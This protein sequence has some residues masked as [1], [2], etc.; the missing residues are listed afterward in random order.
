MLQ[1]YYL[2]F[3]L[4]G[5][6]QDLIHEVSKDRW[7][8]LRMQLSE[9]RADTSPAAFICFDT[10]NGRSIAIN[11]D[12]LQAVCYLW[13]LAAPRRDAAT[14]DVWS[15]LKLV[16]K[17]PWALGFVDDAVSVFDFFCALELG[18][19]MEPFPSFKDEDGEL[20]QV[21]AEE[22]VWFDVPTQL[23]AR[24]QDALD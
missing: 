13:N 12:Q 10:E 22:V 24:G 17:E 7:D 15:M 3:I 21:R 8:Q 14:D 23:L 6:D 5:N 2:R 1:R 18:C 19:D 16:G 20:I 11:P 9:R 4:K